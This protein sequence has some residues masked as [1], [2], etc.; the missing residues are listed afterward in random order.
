MERHLSFLEWLRGFFFWNAWVTHAC[1]RCHSKLC[2][3]V[4]SLVMTEIENFMEV[5]R[6]S[7]N[8]SSRGIGDRGRE[9]E[10]RAD[11]WTDRMGS[12]RNKK[13]SIIKIK[14]Q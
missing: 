3:A 1:S 6:V 13:K 8:L 14:D 2:H 11:R 12:R 9:L 10:E 5:N 7:F 4:A